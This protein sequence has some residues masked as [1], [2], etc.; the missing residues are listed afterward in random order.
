MCFYTRWP[1]QF[2]LSGLIKYT[3]DLLL[4]SCMYLLYIR[5]LT[6]QQQERYIP[7]KIFH[8]RAN[9]CEVHSCPTFHVGHSIHH[10][11]P[12]VGLC[13]VQVSS[14]SRCFATWVRHGINSA[15][16][17]VYKNIYPSF[18]DHLHTVDI[19]LAEPPKSFN[20]LYVLHDFQ[21]AGA[22]I[23]DAGHRTFHMY[24]W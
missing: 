14:T 3:I 6:S 2:F 16:L 4:F 7:F 22:N 9:V 5:I 11:M 20:C 19:C 24:F 23:I 13:L 15:Y 17:G 10:S 12:E 1:V 18:T 21:P 8:E